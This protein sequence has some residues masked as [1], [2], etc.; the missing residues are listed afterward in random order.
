MRNQ[1]QYSGAKSV[2]QLKISLDYL[3]PEIW[4]RLLVPGD[5]TLAR[6]HHIFQAAMGWTDYHLHSFEVRGRRYGV[7][8]PD[9]GDNVLD[10]SRNRLTQIVAAGDRFTYEYDFGDSW[11]HGIIVE[12]L[13]RNV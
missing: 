4:R 9:W 6:L 12:S 3:E 8:N 11:T 13:E 5:C 2:V 7:P 1:P 10:E